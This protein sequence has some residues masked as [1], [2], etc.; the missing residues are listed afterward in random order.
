MLHGLKKFLEYKAYKMRLESLQMTTKAGS[1]HPTSALSCA[2]IVAALF[3][4][5][6]RFDPDNFNDPNNDH[7]ILSKGHASPVLY[8]AWKELGKITEQE[9]MTY[10]QFGS[11]FEGHATLRF[12]YA[13]AATGSLGIGLSIGAGMALAGRLDERDFYTYVLMGDSEITEGSVWEAAEIAA[14]YKMSRLVGIVDCNRLGQTTQTIHGYHAQRYAQK[15]EAFGWKALVIDGHDMQQIVNALDKARNSQEHPTVIIAKTIKGYGIDRVENKEGFHGKAFSQKELE[16]ILPAFEQRFAAVANNGLSYQWAPNL[17][18]H[19]NN[20]S[21]PST[22]SPRTVAGSD[23]VNDMDQK[24]PFVVSNANGVYRTISIKESHYKKGEEIPTRKAYGQSLTQLGAASKEVVSL[25]AEVKNSTF[26]DI[27]EAKYPERFFQCFVAEQ[28]MVGMGIGF[29]RRHK[30]PFI[31]TFACFF[32]RAYDQIRM[33]AIGTS[34][35]R[36]V[37]SHAGVSIGQDGPSQMG[38]EDIAIMRALPES[39]VL[40]PSDAASTHALVEQ[41]VNYHQGISYLRTTRGATPVIYDN[42]ENFP[43]GGCKVLKSSGADKALIIAA[44]ITLHEAL[45]AYDMLLAEGIAVAVIDLYSIK[46]LDAKTIEQIAMQSGDRIITAED[47]YIQGGLG[48]SV[49]YALRNT[50]I[51]IHCLAVTQLPMSGKPDEL[52]AWAGID[53]AAMV[54][55]VKSLI[56]K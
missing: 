15:F 5:A 38:L 14:Y 36:L 17:P 21:N 52:L 46:P 49:V 54:K 18:P 20:R 24:T 7:F 51:E 29:A 53:A 1:G 56:K 33:A 32:S 34:P 28:N 43:I 19:D 3:F 44:G 23:G 42:D 48:E 40:Y 12:P 35:L 25:D 30:I 41:M 26:A 50:A 31:S 6:M 47:H 22:S 27:F 13:E 10:R 8:A 4:Y 37:G 2:D 45:K 11:P 16:E 9:L 55:K 39:I